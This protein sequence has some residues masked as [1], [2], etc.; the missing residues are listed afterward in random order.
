LYFFPITSILDSAKQYGPFDLIFEA[1]GASQVVFESMQAVGK[2][3][4][5]VVSSVTGGDK[6]VEV[7]ADKINLALVLG[8]KLLVGTVNA[9]REYFESCVRDMAL[10]RQC[11]LAG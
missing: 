7:P 6:K 4:A 9:N 5:L 8:N 10:D 2:N 3:G 11:I 1:T